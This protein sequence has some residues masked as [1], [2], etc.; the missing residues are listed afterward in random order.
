V[1]RQLIAPYYPQ[2]NRVVER[3]NGTVVGAARS[4]L[5]AKKL[6]NWFWGEAVLAAVYILNKTP[7]KSVEGTTPF[8]LWYGKK[9]TVQNLRTFGL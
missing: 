6:P 2:Q 1:K 3:K 7:T 8:E 9:L 4:M 5:K